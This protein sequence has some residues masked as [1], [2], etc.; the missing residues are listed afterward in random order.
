[1]ELDILYLLKLK[2]MISYF[3]IRYFIRVK[4]GITC[5]ISHNYAKIDVDSHNF[6]PLEKTL[7]LHN[8]IIF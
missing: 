2:N 3:M 7:T 5:V 1:M 4:S 6:L 8:V